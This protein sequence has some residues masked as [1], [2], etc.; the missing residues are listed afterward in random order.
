MPNADAGADAVTQPQTKQVPSMPSPRRWAIPL[1]DLAYTGGK[2]TNTHDS[3][4]SPLRRNDLELGL[5]VVVVVVI[6]VIAN[7]AADKLLRF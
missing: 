7:G 1:C 5:F 3:R 4:A 6:I 2:H